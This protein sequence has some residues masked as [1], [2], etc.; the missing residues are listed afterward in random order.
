MYR[1]DK[2][3]DGRYM[4]YRHMTNNPGWLFVGRYDNAEDVYAYMGANRYR[5]E[6]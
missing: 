2:D 3:G 6:A 4:L 5:W 1:V